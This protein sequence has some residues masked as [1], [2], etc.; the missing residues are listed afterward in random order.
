[1]ENNILKIFESNVFTDKLMKNY[2]SSKMYKEYKSLIQ[3]KQ[4]LTIDV[5]NEIAKAMRIWA[6]KKGATHFTH[7]F[8]PMTGITAEKHDS[9]LDKNLD[10]EPISVF[11][12][13]SLIK[14][15]PD[16]SSFPSG[17]M[18]TT[19][20]AR[21]YTVWDPTSPVFILNNTLYIPTAFCSYSGESLDKKTPLLKSIDLLNKHTTRLLKVLGYDVNNVSATVGTEQEYFLIDKAMYEKRPDLLNCGRTLFGS[22]PVKGQ[23][24]DDHYFGHIKQ[25]VASYMA[26]LNKRLWALGIY[27]K[28]E[29]NEVA[30]AQHELASV[31][32]YSN[33]ATDNNQL[34]MMLMKQV[35]FEHKMVCL[36]HEKPFE[37]LNGSGKHVNWSLSANGE[38]LLDPSKN[39]KNNL[40]FLLLLVATIKAVDKYS[41]LLRV[42]VT[43]AS[44]DHRLGGHEAPPAIVSIFLGDELTNILDSIENNVD[45]HEKIKER[46]RLDIQSIPE[47]IKDTSDRN[48]TS[49]FAF[50]GNKFEFRMVGSMQSIADPNMIL[51]T[52]VASVIDEFATVLEK[53]ND[54]T[55]TAFDIIKNE[56]KNHKRVVYNGNGYSEEWKK[57]A[58]L[59][60]LAN[61][62]DT[63]ESLKC[64]LDKKNIELF[65]KC[66]IFTEKEIKARQEI[67]LENYCK[68][69]IIEAGTMLDMVNHIIIPNVIDYKSVVADAI[70]KLE[71]IHGSTILEREIL[72]KI[73]EL[74]D[75]L[76][77][78]KIKLLSFIE[79]YNNES[80]YS[81]KAKICSETILNEMNNLRVIV[82][83]LENVVAKKYWQ[84]PTY[85]DMLYSVND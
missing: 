56:Y 68:T 77:Y 80:N 9:F 35:A 1:M 72:G 61:Y 54:V 21:G 84:L 20:E 15:E 42:S 45:Y 2:L 33:I 4:P 81:I 65:E 69:I 14:G 78:A 70:M 19:F 49:P 30:P 53:S 13:K 11:T 46:I 59:R 23:E 79:K 67:L 85:F 83:S 64:L 55:K 12:G 48:R 31:Y 40:R 5:A 37:Y 57:E 3:K 39:P 26:D 44:N 18:R 51:N 17:G 34:T 63:P 10:N 7:W 74:S 6:I 28:T 58:A 32:T 22:Q 24:L 71:K 29:H 43:S 50:T 73:S 16:A 62:K 27:S 76:N 38:N 66:N 8:Q 75:K 41:D 36:L 25:R 52:I 82:D 60:G 47:L